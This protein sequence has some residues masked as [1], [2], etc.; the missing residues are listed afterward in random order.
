M[1]TSK[2]EFIDSDNIYKITI[3]KSDKPKGMAS[4]RPIAYAEVIQLWQSDRSFRTFFISL[5]ADSSFEAYFWETPPITIST[6]EREF[7][8]VLVNSSSLATVKANSHS[9]KQYFDSE[10]EII[11]FA[12]LGN[13]ALLV[14]PCP[15]ADPSIYPHLASFMRNAP[16][17]QQHLLWQNVGK[18]IERKLKLSA[19]VGKHFGI[20][21]LLASYSTGFLS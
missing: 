7:E 16:E 3:F 9:F 8:F 6:V 15:I 14:V 20:R 12:N 2:F 11:T 1:W 21:S 19:Y 4:L 18:E 10:K 17:S 5:L 13:D